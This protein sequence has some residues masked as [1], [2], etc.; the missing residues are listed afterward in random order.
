M[1][2]RSLLQAAG[3]C[4]RALCVEIVHEELSLLSRVRELVAFAASHILAAGAVPYRLVLDVTLLFVV[5]VA[6]AKVVLSPP[7]VVVLLAASEI[8]VSYTHLTLPTT[9]Y[10]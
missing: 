10:V 2:W 5:E 3:G 6:T 7:I 1:K 8:A 4:C 9:P